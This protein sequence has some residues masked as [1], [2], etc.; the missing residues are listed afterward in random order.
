MKTLVNGNM[1]TG[2]YS[3]DFD[4]ANLNSGLYFYKLESGDFK[5]VR[6]MILVK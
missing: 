3:V 4:A 5:E 1:S 6:K 2:S